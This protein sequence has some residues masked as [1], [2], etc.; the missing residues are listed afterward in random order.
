MVHITLC[1]HLSIG[2]LAK[3]TSVIMQFVSRYLKSQLPQEIFYLLNELQLVNLSIAFMIKETYLP[4][5]LYKSRRAQSPGILVYSI[6]RLS[7]RKILIYYSVS[8]Y[9][10]IKVVS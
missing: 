8:D 4:Y 2:D 5:E 7:I 6:Q 1:A 9:R 3:A 10:R